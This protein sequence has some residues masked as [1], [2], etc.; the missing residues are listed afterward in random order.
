MHISTTKIPST[1]VY[2][3]TCIVISAQAFATTVDEARQI[4]VDLQPRI[5][6]EGHP[7]E[8][9]TLKER[10]AHYNVPGVSIAF[11]K[12][13]KV[14]WTYTEGVIDKVTNR[15]VDEHTVFQ[16]ASISKPVF[17]TTLMRY[18]AEH[19][20]DL[21]ADV[22]TLLT[23]WKLPEHKWQAS[24]PVTLRRLLSHS[25]GTT[26]H[27]F[28][29]YTAGENVPTLTGVLNGT[30]PANSAAVVVDIE[31][32]TK[33]RYSGGGTTLAQLAL[34]DVSGEA[35][36]SMAKRYIF[37]PLNM[38]RS[39]Y[40]QPLNA[41]LS[42]NA[43]VPYNSSGEPVPGGAHTYAT[44]AAAGLWTTPSDLLR[45]AG[46][47]QRAHNGSDQSFLSQT[48]TSEILTRQSDQVGV[49]FFLNNKGEV[50]SFSH[51]GA[52]EGFRANLFA[53]TETGD[54]VAVMTNGDNGGALI[55][56]ILTR[57]SE[58]YNWQERKPVIK[59]LVEL[60]SEQLTSLAGTY[61]TD[62]SDSH[63]IIVTTEG[64]TIVV[65]IG[66]F[67][68]DQVFYPEGETA[69][70]TMKGAS[71]TFRHNTDSKVISLNYNGFVDANKV[72]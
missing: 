9:S 49:G 1:L 59:T 24:S 41:D 14:A 21:D 32:G 63:E 58:L 12:N 66:E 35:L 2:A 67:V 42:A 16:A 31:P 70:F 53:H 43:A 40:A 22:N 8:L 34:Q 18:R 46:A 33:F 11:M 62:D 20:L 55:A 51:G 19:G 71:L 23:S 4:A 37:E 28:R 56:E 57:I 48:T 44:M 72:K 15:P 60:T 10:M 65:N 50:T 27:G 17:A 45:L 54:G 29:G 38:R 25:A 7:P 47:I 52:N 5:R 26:V 68:V 69:F 36:A 39:A 61:I 13:H 6:I 3:I 64:E 30:P